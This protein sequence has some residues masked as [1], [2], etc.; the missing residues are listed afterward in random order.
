MRSLLR[1]LRNWCRIFTAGEAPFQ[2]RSACLATLFISRHQTAIFFRYAQKRS[3]RYAT[4]TK[5]P[6]AQPAPP[7][8]ITVVNQAKQNV[9][10]SRNKIANLLSGF[11][12]HEY[13]K[14]RALRAKNKAA[15]AYPY[16]QKP[17]WRGKPPQT[18]PKRSGYATGVM[19]FACLHLVA[20]KFFSVTTSKISTQQKP[21]RRRRKGCFEGSVIRSVNHATFPMGETNF[22]P[23]PL[24]GGHP[25]ANASPR[26]G[27]LPEVITKTK[28]FNLRIEVN[29]KKEH[30]ARFLWT[31]LQF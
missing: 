16:A 9:T 2:G 18:P 24:L 4:F 10:P 5:S 22:P 29:V 20:V 14:S 6:N 7:T 26:C 15:F 28:L 8:H 30:P 3:L 12:A 13:F 23:N 25:P 31:F 17:L 27:F 19:P 1:P 11:F 21:K